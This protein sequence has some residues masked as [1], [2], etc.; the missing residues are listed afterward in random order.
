MAHPALEQDGKQ[1][2][3]SIAGSCL[4]PRSFDPLN[5]YGARWQGI[6]N[7]VS[8]IIRCTLKGFVY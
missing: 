5:Q 8:E 6:Q 1:G 3:S 4:P 7:M 2:A